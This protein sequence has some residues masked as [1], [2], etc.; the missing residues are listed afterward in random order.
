MK[1]V[2]LLFF[3]FLSHLT[4]TQIKTPIL[5]LSNKN[6]KLIVDG[7]QDTIVKKGEPY[8]VILDEGEHIIQIVS[9]N[10]TL[11][12]TVTC[13]GEKQ[14]ILKIGFDDNTQVQKITPDNIEKIVTNASVTLPGALSDIPSIVNKYYAFDK[15]DLVK[16]SFN[17]LN[18]KGTINFYFYSYPD[19]QL[20]Y[21]REYA[22]DL[23]EQT[24]PINK[25]GVYRF[26]FST[27]HIFDRNCEFIVKRI[28]DKKGN[29]DFK[30]NVTV[31]WDTTYYDVL[32]TKVRVYSTTNFDHTNRT[33]VRVNLPEETTYWVY[34]IGVGQESMKQ[35]E[36][37]ISQLSKGAAGL[38][39]DPLYAF[40]IGLIGELP[41]FKST[42]TV[43]YTFADNQN[44]NLFMADSSYMK[45]IFKE[46][47]N[48]T[49]DYSKIG[50]IPRELNFCL[51]NMNSFTGHDVEIKVGAFI[52]KGYYVP[53]EN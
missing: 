14:R 3:L 45:Y 44:S 17:L 26:V 37:F 41:M 51:W 15:G 5:I 53:E 52:I 20:I 24:I 21:S 42:A 11:T 27:N 1:T 9:D 43:N 48:I 13:I 31:K 18:K 28:P 40:G 38:V 23:E 35:M 22:Q 30:T 6:G 29:P 25:R 46:G 10:E 12:E 19:D 8:K 47:N 32:D 50:S 16:F 34:W 49:T 36:N 2:L 39:V 7:L 4:F 33:V